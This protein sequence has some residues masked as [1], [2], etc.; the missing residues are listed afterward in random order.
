VV[1]GVGSVEIGGVAAP[2]DWV[3]GSDQVALRSAA[4]G[5]VD[6]TW[7]L[8]ER[9]TWVLTSTGSVP[10]AGGSLILEAPIHA[11]SAAEAP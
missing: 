5:P 7:L 4:T 11:R 2:F 9:P 6:V 1:V 10:P 8:S 3:P